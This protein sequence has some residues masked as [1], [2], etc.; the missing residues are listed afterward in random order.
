MVLSPDDL[1][2]EAKIPVAA[3]MPEVFTNASSVYAAAISEGAFFCID[4]AT[5]EITGKADVGEPFVMAVRDDRVVTLGH[6]G[7]L[8]IWDPH[9][10]GARAQL[11]VGQPI[12]GQWMTW[13]GSNLLVTAHGTKADEK[14]GVLHV[15]ALE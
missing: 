12:Q 1:A 4:P 13:Y 8:M 10:C 3:K 14:D 9:K 15:L 5:R 7:K 6:S 2:I 11:S